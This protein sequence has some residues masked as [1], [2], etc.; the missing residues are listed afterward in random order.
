MLSCRVQSAIS[1]CFD[2]FFD[3][4]KLEPDD[5]I[6]HGFERAPPT[7]KMAV[8]PII[9]FALTFKARNT[10]NRVISTAGIISL[11]THIC[12]SVALNIIVHPKLTHEH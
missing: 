3:Y 12:I 8:R 11:L 4:R 5:L 10:D 2:C 1:Q 7:H 6:A 9:I